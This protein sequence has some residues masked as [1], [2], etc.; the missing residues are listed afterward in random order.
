MT[1][2]SGLQKE[3]PPGHERPRKDDDQVHCLGSPGRYPEQ[4]HGPT[5]DT[6]EGGTEKTRQIQ[7][8]P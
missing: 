3:P 6:A 5:T 4:A 1:S 7:E 2:V 8:T